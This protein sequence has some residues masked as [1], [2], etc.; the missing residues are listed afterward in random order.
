M[1]S[2]ASGKA[3]S[4][5]RFKSSR[6]SATLR[7][8]ASK[9]SLFYSSQRNHYASYLHAPCFGSA[10]NIDSHFRKNDNRGI[11]GLMTSLRKNSGF[12]L[13]ELSVV[14]TIIAVVMAM[15][16]TSFIGNLEKSQEDDTKARMKII[17]QAL[18]DFRRAHGRLP[19]PANLTTALSNANFGVSS[20]QMGACTGGTPASNFST[21]LSRTATVASGAT[22][23]TSTNTSGVL[24]YAYSIFNATA[25]PQGAVLSAITSGT[26]ATSAAPS[27][28]AI[29]GQ[30]VIY[31]HV[32]AG[33]VPVRTLNLPDEYAMDG[34]GRRIFYGVS[35]PLTAVDGFSTT[36]VSNTAS[37]ITI[38]N[39]N[40]TAITS[41]AAYVLVSY[42][43]NGHGAF[44]R[45]GGVARL[46]VG[47]TNTNE[48]ENCGRTVDGASSCTTTTSTLFDSVFVQSFPTKDTSN[49]LNSFDDIV[50]YATR[51]QLRVATE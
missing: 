23:I 41:T 39:V 22:A 24:A 3:L 27:S 44:P 26:A 10:R 29:T 45:D 48:R 36:P 35:A 43:V 20:A 49:P 4:F 16:L 31:G 5:L 1:I 19:C 7:F 51:S 15:T 42:G 37:R 38:N 21:N 8:K 30:A 11:Y 32:A 6:S 40:G 28:A 50:M 9:P 17:Q 13:L 18:L 47:S 2:T 12:S 34:W 14:L 25:F 33:A 46:D